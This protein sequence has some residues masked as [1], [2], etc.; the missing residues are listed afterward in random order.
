MIVFFLTYSA[1]YNNHCNK[2]TGNVTI[3]NDVSNNAL[4]LGPYI[5]VD[6]CKI[7]S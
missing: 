1:Y 6:A 5:S 4:L 7:I 3:E 2:Y